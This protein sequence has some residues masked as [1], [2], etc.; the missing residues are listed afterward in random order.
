MSKKPSKSCDIRASLYELF[1]IPI[2]EPEG[3]WYDESP[4]AARSLCTDLSFSTVQTPTRNLSSPFPHHFRKSF[5]LL[6]DL[7]CLERSS[8]NAAFD[9]MAFVCLKGELSNFARNRDWTHSDVDH[10]LSYI[11]RRHVHI[12][13]TSWIL[14]TRSCSWADARRSDPSNECM[15]GISKSAPRNTARFPCTTHSQYLSLIRYSRMYT[16]PV[17]SRNQSHYHPYFEKLEI[18]LSPR[19][20]SASRSLSM[21]IAVTSQAA[22]S[23]SAWPSWPL[24]QAPTRDYSALIRGLS[25]K[26]CRA[27]FTERSYSS[28]TLNNNN[29]SESTSI[30]IVEQVLR[31]DGEKRN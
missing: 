7:A 4:C 20:I 24:L 5:R 14:Q 22:K 11:P 1:S 26:K 6:L 25:N 3:L 18:P 17:E 15:R 27:V 28:H 16:S 12:V 2:V 21:R 19:R 31:N 23:T 13:S 9:T 8:G 30:F 10:K 29:L